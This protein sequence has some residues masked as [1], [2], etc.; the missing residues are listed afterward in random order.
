MTPSAPPTPEPMHRPSDDASRPRRPLRRLLPP[1]L[2][3]ALA[4]GSGGLLAAAIS[5]P[6]PVGDDAGR[7]REGA[8]ERA[9]LEQ[10]LVLAEKTVRMLGS[11]QEEAARPP[12]TSERPAQ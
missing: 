7:G 8:L 4:A 10:G 11:L 6:T 1:A 9:R 5:G 2:V 3:L 12:A